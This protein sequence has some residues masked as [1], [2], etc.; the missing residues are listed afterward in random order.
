MKH[1]SRTVYSNKSDERPGGDGEG[2]SAPHATCWAP[3]SASAALIRIDSHWGGPVVPRQHPVGFCDPTLSPSFCLLKE[4][5][6]CLAME[7]VLALCVRVYRCHTNHPNRNTLSN[8]CSSV[9]C[10]TWQKVLSPY[11]LGGRRKDCTNTNKQSE[12]V[13]RREA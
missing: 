1:K 12:T 5:F 9:Q 4:N 8:S 2:N 6:L 11:H 7:T 10:M 13:Y 3:C